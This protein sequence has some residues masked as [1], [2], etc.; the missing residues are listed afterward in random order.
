MNIAVIG[1]NGQ[2]G[3]EVCLFLSVFGV[4]VVPI[5]RTE[6]GGI[7]LERCGLSCRYGTIGNIEDAKRLLDGCDLIADFSH[8]HGL[9]TEVRTAVKSNIENAL[10]WAPAKSPYVY[11]STISAFGMAHGRSKM[12]NYRL[13]HTRYA[14]DKRYLERLVLAGQAKRDVYVLR[15]GQLHGYLQKVS[16]EF[17]EE[18]ALGEEVHLPFSSN[19]ASYTVFCFTI[20]EALVNIALGKEKPGRY[21]LVSTPSW[22]WGEVYAHWARQCNSKLK[23]VISE[24]EESKKIDSRSLLKWSGFL[25]NP[26][27]CFGVTYRE[28]FMNYL[29]A[30][31]PK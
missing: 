12:R 26:V 8:P 13:A 28:L 6:L 5:S 19:T 16:Q 3:R 9:P 17:M 29:F 23:L 2:V 18:A 14:A 31:F 27:I 1:A 4:K 15:L 21:T 24:N 11:M 10:R 20:A 7:F 30:G 22:T 25:T